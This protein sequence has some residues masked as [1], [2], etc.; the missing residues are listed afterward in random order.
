[1]GE[2]VL[3]LY[4]RALAR[5]DATIEPRGE[6]A[7]RFP[8]LSPVDLARLPPMRERVR[9]VLP[10][11]GLA[12]FFGPS[13]CG[14]S[15]LVLDLLG[16]VTTGRAWFG[17]AVTTPCKAVYLAL[18]GEAGVSKR[19]QAFIAKH[20]EPEVL[21]VILSPLDIRLEL[22]RRALVEAIRAAG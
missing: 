21:R 17:H 10:E 8:L 7:P 16:A 19:V 12:A 9:G 4:D 14:K 15:F 22:D 1:M 2:N 3:S 6:T 11:T 13:G 5:I 20:G 18:E